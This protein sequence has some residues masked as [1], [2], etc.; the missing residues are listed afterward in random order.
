[1]S[2]PKQVTPL[3]LVGRASREINP[4]SAV[5][6]ELA[7]SLFQRPLMVPAADVAR[8]AFSTST[9]WDEVSKKSGA[10]KELSLELDRLAHAYDRRVFQAEHPAPPVSPADMVLTIIVVVP[11]LG[12]LLVLLL[13]TERW[14]RAA[15]LGFSTILVLGAVSLSGVMALAAQEAAGAAWRARS[16][17]TATHAIF[18]A[19]NPVNERGRPT[20]AGTLVL[21]D[22]SLLVLAPTM[23]QPLW[24]QRVAAVV[25]GVY[26]VAAAAMSARVLFIARQQRRAHRVVVET[27]LAGAG[28]EALPLGRWWWQPPSRD[29]ARNA[30]EGRDTENESGG[31][32]GAAAVE[33]RRG[34]EVVI[35]FPATGAP[36]WP[37]ATVELP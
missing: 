3:K 25:C 19:G 21:V 1:M 33:A 20:L 9:G 37:L 16:T 31:D 23:Y 34:S 18:P 14:G 12:A 2:S 6:A 22:E 27:P 7:A 26:I 30:E 4:S 28:D 5:E 36:T 29:S 24:V 13:T 8:H 17:R 11:E 35:A 32:G 10:S 15:L